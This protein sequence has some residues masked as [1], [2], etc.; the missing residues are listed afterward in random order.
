MNEDD[1][2]EREDAGGSLL[3]TQHM[4]KQMRLKSAPNSKPRGVSVAFRH[5]SYIKLQGHG[6]SHAK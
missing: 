5:L 3:W 2:R 6:R 1:E 4:N